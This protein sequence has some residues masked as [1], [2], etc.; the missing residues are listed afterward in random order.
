MGRRRASK[1]SGLQRAQRITKTND[2]QY[3]KW[4]E[5]LASHREVDEMI[6][7]YLGQYHASEVERLQE[8][9]AELAKRAGIAPAEEP[10]PE[11]E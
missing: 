6:R 4:L 9:V 3:E 5:M 2:K 1:R 11:G 8:V 7:V 10:K